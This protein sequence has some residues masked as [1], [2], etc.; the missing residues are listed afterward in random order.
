MTTM[1][2]VYGMQDT[3]DIDRYIK[4]GDK[5]LEYFSIGA[6]PGAFMV[7]LIPARPCLC[8]CITLA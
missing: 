4:V 7:D 8:I 1:N 5:M 3:D 2:I 6:Q